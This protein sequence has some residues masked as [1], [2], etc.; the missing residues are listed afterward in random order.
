MKLWKNL[1]QTGRA[2]LF[3]DWALAARRPMT[4]D[5]NKRPTEIIPAIKT[6]SYKVNS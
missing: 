6:Q 1:N 2:I 4:K 5:P 3:K